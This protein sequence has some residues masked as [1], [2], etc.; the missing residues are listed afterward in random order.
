MSPNKP[1]PA[2]KF[3]QALDPADEP[4]RYLPVA[5]APFAA[6]VRAVGD[7]LAEPGP[8]YRRLKASEKAR[9]QVMQAMCDALRATGLSDVDVTEEEWQAHCHGLYEKSQEP[10]CP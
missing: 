4:E 3:D 9:D 8:G 5:D 1:F 7:W 6:I 10:E 2:A